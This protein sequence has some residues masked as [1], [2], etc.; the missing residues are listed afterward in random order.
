MELG[1]ITLTTSVTS[2]IAAVAGVI[3]AVLGRHNQVRIEIVRDLVNGHASRQDTRIE[4]LTGSLAAS[5]IEV[6]Q[7][8]PPGDH[9]A[10]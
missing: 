10:A 7:S 8:A 3:A 2:V 9:A 1:D 6:P 5:G 4:Q